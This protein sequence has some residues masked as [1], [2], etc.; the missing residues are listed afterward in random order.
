[1]EMESELI[2]LVPEKTYAVCTNGLK[3]GEMVVTSHDLYTME[4]GRLIATLNDK[5]TNF[6]CV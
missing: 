4:D 6:A 3:K 5:P 1:M 2:P